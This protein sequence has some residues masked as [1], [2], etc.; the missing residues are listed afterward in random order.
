MAQEIVTS[1]RTYNGMSA[2]EKAG[3]PE[4][5]RD[6]PTDEERQAAILVIAETF[7][8]DVAESMIVEGYHPDD[9]RGLIKSF[10]AAKAEPVG[11]LQEYA[12]KAA[13]LYADHPSMVPPPKEWNGKP[14]NFLSG[15]EKA[16]ALKQH[17]ME[18]YGASLAAKAKLTEELSMLGPSGKPR[19]SPRVGEELAH[20]LLHSPKD[21]AAA[22]KNADQLAVEL[23][24]VALQYRDSY[25]IAS[26]ATMKALAEKLDPNS[27]KLVY[28]FQQANDYHD[29]KGK[30]LKTTP[31]DGKPDDD[32][33]SE[34][35]KPS[36]ILSGLKKA[37][38]FFRQSPGNDGQHRSEKLFTNRVVDRLRA[39]APE[40]AAVVQ[41]QVDK[42][43]A[44]QYEGDLKKWKKAHEKWD[45]ARA[46]HDKTQ[47][48]G[49]AGK[50]STPFPDSEP[51]EPTPPARYGYSAKPAKGAP[52]L[53]DDLAKRI[54]RG[55]KA[56]PRTKAA[57]RVAQRYVSTY[58]GWLAMDQSFRDGSPGRASKTAIYHGVKPYADD[59]GTYPDWKPAHQRD[60]GETD[61]E[62]ILTS[63]KQWLASPQTK[64]MEK[65]AQLRAA[66]DLAVQASDYNRKL[67]PAVYNMLLAR[68]AGVPEPGPGQTLQ[69]VRGSICAPSEADDTH[70]GQGPGKP[71]TETTMTTKLSAE[72]SKQASDILTNLDNLAETVKAKF[73]SWGMTKGDAKKVV[74][75][76]DAVA[77]NF[78]R[79]T[80]GE[81]SLQ[82]RKQEVL[83]AVLQRDSDEPYM[84]T[85]KN[86]HQP[87]QTDADEPYMGAYGD[88]QSSAVDTGKAEDGKALVP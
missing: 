43:E 11:N 35:D 53:F 39:L 21:P 70:P 38:D 7:P 5:K 58:P 32:S 59:P 23:F 34:R 37:L 77:D 72:Q 30:F 68:L 66:L 36:K 88:D 20:H 79:S 9:V 65:D 55:P 26:P 45:K 13:D 44:K 54:K 84:D 24:Q 52:S 67:H 49:G 27:Q 41:V 57:H 82:R 1:A 33:F 16:V 80:F 64:S 62:Q 87:V 3:I 86:P 8:P 10:H 2:A 81:E 75:G 6:E 17:Q 61:F 60:L 47:P 12:K 28:A 63:A 51:V 73:A 76:L 71:T 74:N 15:D 18:V 25:R 40:K 29:A 19:V 42:R 14:F 83:A 50:G 31:G 69:T 56:K 78:E 85:F 48:F 4:P 22:A 46:K